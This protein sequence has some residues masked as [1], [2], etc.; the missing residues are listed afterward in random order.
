M[1]ASPNNQ[2]YELLELTR[3]LIKKFEANMEIF[4]R[5]G[6][7]RSFQV[8]AKEVAD[9]SDYE[10]GRVIIDLLVALA[11]SMRALTDHQLPS[12]ED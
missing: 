5:D 1:S 7:A 2:E 11:S 4:A 3:Q 6:N 10:K 12:L 9:I 8:M